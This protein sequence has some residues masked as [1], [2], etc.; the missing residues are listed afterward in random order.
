MFLNK[1][2]KRVS[3]LFPLIMAQSVNSCTSLPACKRLLNLEGA[4][5]KHNDVIICGVEKLSSSKQ[6]IIFFG[7]DVQ[8]Y[9]ENMESHYTNKA[10]VEWNLESTA[11]LLR[12]KFPDSTVFVIKPSDMLLKTFSIYKNFLNFDEDGK[13]EFT[14]DFGAL[15]HLSKL[16]ASALEKV[17]S[18]DVN[19]ACS[20][21][22]N[23][24]SDDVQVKIIGFS[25]GCVVLSQLMYELDHFKDDKNVKLFL[26]KVSAIYW[27]DGGHNGGVKGYITDN[28][29]LKDIKKLEKDL[30]VLVTPYQIKCI[31][32]RWIGKEEAEF[33]KKLEALGAK[34]QE[35]RYFMD[36]PG[37]I[38]NHFKVLTK[39]R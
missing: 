10:Y 3:S 13:P 17:G 8:D 18:S 6:H 2:Y 14:N 11:E 33:V 22:S 5:G 31:N 38:E 37:S 28:K 16:Y 7:G 19:G 32:R 9:K 30:F 35:F 21:D 36:E 26:D 27:L 12:S 15:V 29:V 25:K 39:V 34:I 4:E 20:A 1:I 24:C 23:I